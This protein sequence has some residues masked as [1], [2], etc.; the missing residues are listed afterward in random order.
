MTRPEA[1]GDARD[2]R[3]AHNEVIFRTVNERIQQQALAFGGLDTYEFI[4]ECATTACLERVPLTIRDYDR[5]RGE[6]ATFV[7]VPGH[8]YD[9]IELVVERQPAYWVVRKDGA[10]GVVAEFADPRDGES[11]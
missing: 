10:A 5:I 6:G 7:V 2:E 8:V 1:Q 11:A 4:C 9:E 3:L